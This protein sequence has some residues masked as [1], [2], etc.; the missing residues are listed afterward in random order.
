[1]RLFPLPHR[2]LRSASAQLS[3][4][5]GHTRAGVAICPSMQCVNIYDMYIH[6]ILDMLVCG[7]QV[8]TSTGIDLHPS[9]PKE[10]VLI[11]ILHYALHC[12]RRK[13]IRSLVTTLYGLFLVVMTSF[14]FQPVFLAEVIHT[15]RIYVV[16]LACAETMN[17]TDYSQTLLTLKP[18]SSR[19]FL[20][21]HGQVG[22]T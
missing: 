1:M 9:L 12:F 11:G 18:D 20:F 13:C 16:Y 10:T 21:M 17:E 6:K 22:C 3:A 4:N 19:A 8:F 5:P 15:F 14:S 2:S 7:L